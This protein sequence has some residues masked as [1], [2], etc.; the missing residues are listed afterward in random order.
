MWKSLAQENSRWMIVRPGRLPR[1]TRVSRDFPAPRST[2]LGHTAR[3]S[4]TPAYSH[5]PN[6]YVFRAL[7]AIQATL[8]HIPARMGVSFPVLKLQTS[9]PTQRHSAEMC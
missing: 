4:A 5:L 8:V 3:H 6:K 1:P 2:F 7:E 9:I